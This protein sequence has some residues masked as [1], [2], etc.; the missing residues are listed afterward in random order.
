MGAT[1]DK[2]VSRLQY[3]LG[4]WG[5]K[6]NEL[7]AKADV[8]SQEATIDARKHLEEATDKLAAAREKL[9]EAKGTGEDK[10]EEFKTGLERSWRE[11]ERAFHKLAH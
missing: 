8:A 2:T 5:A 4:L 10:W 7:L 1:V 11:L 3:E 6:L 9:E